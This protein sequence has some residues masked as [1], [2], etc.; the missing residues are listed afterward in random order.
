MKTILCYGD[1]NVWG[2]IPG[3]YNMESGL[4]KRYSKDVRWTG[5]LQKELG[6]Q[7]EVITE[8][9]NARTTNLDELLP[10]RLFKN[11]L[12]SLPL[13]LDA[14]YPIDLIILWLGTNDTK[15]QF[16]RSAEEIKEGLR[17]LITVIQS[18][19]KGPNNHSPHILIVA[20]QPIADTP[21]LNPIV[22]KAS[23]EKSHQL[24]SL[25]KTLAQE[26]QCSFFDAGLYVTSSHADGFHLEEKEQRIIGEVMAMRV[27]EILET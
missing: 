2:N 21:N 24:A 8:G 1:S 3:S 17:Q 16:N 23:I 14:H 11:G 25:Y 18:S 12:S 7:Y 13:F 27:K 10:G 22:D 6:N 9:M 19:D 20:P 4:S 15:V 5:V 26:E